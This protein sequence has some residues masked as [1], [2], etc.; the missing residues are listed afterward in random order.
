MRLASVIVA[1][2]AC[3]TVARADLAKDYAGRIV[4][5]PD[6]P[7]TLASDLAAYVKANAT[8]GDAYEA[9]KGSPWS[10]NLVGFLPTD[11]TDVMLEIGQDKLPVASKKRLVITSTKLTTA[12]GFESNKTYPVRLVAGKKVLAKATLRLR[13]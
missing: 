10:I 3:V 11:A 7:P 9:I 4:I 12:A 13:D 6:P 5:S 1:I 2:V 8:K